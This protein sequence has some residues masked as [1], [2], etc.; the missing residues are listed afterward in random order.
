MN[1]RIGD[2]NPRSVKTGAGL[3]VSVVNDYITV[4]TS[5]TV[6]F[7]FINIPSMSP[8]LATPM[9]KLVDSIPET[10]MLPNIFTSAKFCALLKKEMFAPVAHYDGITI[11]KFTN[12]E[13]LV[14]LPVS[15]I[16]KTA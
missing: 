16:S 4:T 12:I 11:S 9:C 15:S 2:K 1:Y 13:K 8:S 6:R 14:I 5:L 3:L 10:V 7:N